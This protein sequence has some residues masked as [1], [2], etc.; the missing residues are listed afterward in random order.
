MQKHILM[1]ILNKK[2]TFLWRVYQMLYCFNELFRL[3]ANIAI[4]PM[5]NNIFITYHIAD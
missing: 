4:L 3:F 2:V 1:G 5:L